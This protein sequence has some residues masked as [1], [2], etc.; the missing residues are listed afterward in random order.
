MISRSTQNIQARII[1]TYNLPFQALLTQPQSL[2]SL[3]LASTL[4]FFSGSSY[5]PPKSPAGFEMQMK[6]PLGKGH[7][8][9]DD[10]KGQGH[11]FGLE[12]HSSVSGHKY[13][14]HWLSSTFCSYEAG[15]SDPWWN[16][17]WKKSNMLAD[18]M[19][20]RMNT[21][22]GLRR[23]GC[24]G[25]V[26]LLMSRVVLL[27]SLVILGSLA[28]VFFVQEWVQNGFCWKSW[29]LV[30]EFWGEPCSRLLFFFLFFFFFLLFFF[31]SFF[32]FSCC[33]YI[34]GCVKPHCL[35]SS[36]KFAASCN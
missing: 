13:F 32:K 20:A 19:F 35:P 28:Y 6:L 4:K 3:L 9:C 18:T 17:F 33:L 7:L 2:I 22:R 16:W 14:S 5:L 27:D 31:L 26:K 1:N 23:I 21:K 24:I 30:E 29:V 8:I 10:G 34:D 25:M 11:F 36:I 15:S 12:T